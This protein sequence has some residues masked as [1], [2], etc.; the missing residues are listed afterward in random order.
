MEL[1]TVV[2]KFKK[3]KL[4]CVSE[5]DRPES[6]SQPLWRTKMSTKFSSESLKGKCHLE[7]LGI[8]GKNI[9]NGSQRNGIEGYGLGSWLTTGTSSWMLWSWQLTLGSIKDQDFLSFLRA[10]DKHFGLVCRPER[11]RGKALTFVIF[12]YW[13]DPFS[14]VCVCV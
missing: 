12:H 14:H 8:D 9:K 4:M 13:R 11:A 5:C 1:N 2:E 10:S 3:I 7:D 6:H